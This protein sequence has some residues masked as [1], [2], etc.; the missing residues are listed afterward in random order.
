MYITSSMRTDKREQQSP[1][2]VCIKKTSIKGGGGGQ[3]VCIK[4]STKRDYDQNEANTSQ[5]LPFIPT[6]CACSKNVV[7]RSIAGK[8]SC[9]GSGR[10]RTDSSSITCKNS[11]HKTESVNSQTPE[12]CSYKMLM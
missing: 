2:S 5:L 4:T 7:L 10:A 6:P 11:S 9:S 1:V 12:Y 8:V 3:D